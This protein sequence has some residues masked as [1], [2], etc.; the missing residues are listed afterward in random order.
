MA[1]FISA[2]HNPKGIKIDPGAVGNGF[3]EA[4]LTVE[5]RD[6]V[7][8]ELKKLN[9]PKVICDND[10]ERLSEYLNR[11]KTG[12]G[13]VVLEFHFDAAS[14]PAASGTSSIVGNDADRLDKAFAKELVDKTA[15]V[16]MIKN[17]G[18]ISE[19][20]SH[21]GTLALMREQGTVSLLEICFI[22]NKNDL[23]MYN[24]YKY[25]LAKEIAK[26]IFKYETLV[27]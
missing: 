15:A 12:L 6:M 14:S 16:L 9:L 24:K 18:V 27:P 19:G 7:I 8:S 20:Q 23:A 22:T 21:R 1:V 3:R 25:V 10:S 5:F 4:D 2:G 13:S 11:I 17:R 26:I